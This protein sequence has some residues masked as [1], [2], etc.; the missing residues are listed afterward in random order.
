MQRL[1]SRTDI[2]QYRQISKSCN[3][4]KLN[5]IILDAQIQ[6]LLPLLGE[7]LYNN[8]VASI[9]D[10]QELLTGGIYVHDSLEYTNYG[11]KMLLSYFVYARY[12]MFSSYID[13]PFSLVEK[14]GSDSKPVDASVKKTLYNDNRDS[15]FMIWNNIKNY[16]LRTKAE[17][18]NGCNA[19]TKTRGLRFTKI[20]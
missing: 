13:T 15:A 8:I 1:I 5:E 16:L 18:F 9:E 2:A 3:D 20:K 11:L 12:V 17:D 14:L 10:Y 19:G 7:R 6:D 4:D